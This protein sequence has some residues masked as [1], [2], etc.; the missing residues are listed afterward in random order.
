M[1]VLSVVG[2]RPNFVKTAPVVAALSRRHPEWDNVLVHTGQHY[3]RMMSEIFFEELG[4][5]KPDH[6]LG[7]GPGSHAVQTAR[8]MEALEPVLAEERPDLVIVPGD[9]NSTLAATLVAVKMGLTVAHLESGL[10]SFDRTMPEEI[11]RIVAD[12]FADL[13]FLHSDE[14]IENL[15]REGIEDERMHF[16]GNTMIDSLVAVEER[17]R[18]AGM[19]QRLGVA[20]GEYLLVTLHRPALVDGPL[21]PEVL[22]RL[23]GVAGDLPV[24]FPVHPR[25]RKMMDRLPV[26]DGVVLTDPVGYLDFLSLQADARAVLT[27]SGGVQEETTVLGVPCLTLRENTERP[28]TTT[29]GTNELVG[30]DSERIRAGAQR[31]LTGSSRPARPPLWDGH[32]AVRV[33]A[34][35][36]QGVPAIEWIPPEVAPLVASRLGVASDVST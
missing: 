35:L 22:E 23:S 7:V 19:A 29:S 21:L 14:A 28:I 11:N 3:D 24:V 25:T 5:P 31:A 33:A 34:I 27:D 20:A 1:K 15:R 36:A 6:M 2:T 12:E 4:V 32:T 16:V 13:L 26:S 9:V 18:S 17:M 10:R 30:L 8:T